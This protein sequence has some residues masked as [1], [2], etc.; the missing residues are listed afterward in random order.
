LDWKP[1]ELQ[2]LLNRTVVGGLV[3]SKE[4]SRN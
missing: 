3:A 2:E 1:E 4:V